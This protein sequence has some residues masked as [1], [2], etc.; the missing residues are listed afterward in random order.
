M[1]PFKGKYRFE[2]TTCGKDCGSDNIVYL[3]PDCGSRNR[4]GLPPKGILKTVYDYA[5]LIHSGIDFTALKQSNFAELMPVKSPDSLPP[6]RIGNTPLY[7]IKSLSGKPLSHTLFLKDDAQNPTWSF[8]DRASSLVSAFAKEQGVNRIITASTGNAGS[9][10]AGI[11]ASQNQ[12][13]VV[14]VPEKAPVG[15]LVQIMMY[16]ARLIPVEGTYDDAF[17]LSVEATCKY[18]WYNRNTAFNPITIE[19]KKTV[20]F[21]IFEQLGLSIPSRIFIPAG[22]G[23]ILSGVYKG[24]EDLMKSGIISEIPIMV[25]VQ[26]EGSPNLVRNIG[27]ESFSSFGSNTLADS[28]SVDVPRNFYMASDYLLKYHGEWLTVNDDSILAASGMLAA[29]TGLFAEPASAAAFAGYL[30]YKDN[31][32]AGEGS[33]N[34][35]LLTGSGLKDI[36][37]FIK[38]L[39]LPP[40]V[41]PDLQALEKSLKNQL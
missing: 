34:V 41:K 3:C 21:E 27:K 11:C 18:G 6:L 38:S 20:S 8:K 19:G 33:R 7:E 9:S 15:K 35:V 28:I 13:A 39:K 36:S 37:P 25:A 17:D 26:A 10:L 31:G 12:E 16:G 2:C 1:M 24:F 40:A 30:H 5:G 23:V 14:L 29:E 22:D 4:K 32:L